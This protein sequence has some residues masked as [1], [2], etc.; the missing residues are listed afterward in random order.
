MVVS[1]DIED[2]LRDIAARPQDWHDIGKSS[3]SYVER[4][5]APDVTA[6]NWIALYKKLGFQVD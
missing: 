5:H 2:R 3:R 1:R 4:Y 6:R